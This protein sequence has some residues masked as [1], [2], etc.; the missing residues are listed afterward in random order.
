M[1]ARMSTPDP[2]VPAERAWPKVL[3]S[4]SALLGGLLIGPGIL[5]AAADGPRGP[6]E[7]LQD[8]GLL[9]FGL[10]AL[11]AL[12]LAA[13]VP[14]VPG[15]RVPTALLVAIALLPW[16]VGDIAAL[17][18]AGGLASAV[19][20]PDAAVRAMRVVERIYAYFSGHLAG[21]LASLGLFAGLAPALG[22]AS[23]APA[24]ER[25]WLPGALTGGGLAVLGALFVALVGLVGHL[26]GASAS[27][28]WVQGLALLTA[29]GPL[30]LAGMGAAANER[31]SLELAAGSS[32]AG[33]ALL[34]CAVPVTS[35]LGAVE[36][37]RALA[38]AD[39]EARA[40]LM[41]TA[42]VEVVTL[43]GVGAAAAL[44][45][46][47]V[48]AA[49]AGWAHRSGTL[50]RSSYTGGAVAAG[51][52]LGMLVFHLASAFLARALAGPLDAVG[53]DAGTLMLP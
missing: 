2:S 42:A 39:P 6:A 46:F 13:L 52:V 1:L 30:V 5:V 7:L 24:G 27:M 21:A 19:G 20:E 26:L 38:Y 47:A 53:F 33:A 18:A 35:A 25:R 10:A 50:D 43:F 31:R 9:P 16:L 11:C 4:T 12:V 22:W 40:E 28:L 41:A 8:G 37:F 36:A 14:F 23:I 49:L 32:L 3:A 34:A 29:M 45:G 44:A 15:R 17:L 51:L 48:P